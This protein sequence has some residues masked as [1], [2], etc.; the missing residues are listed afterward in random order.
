M[1]YT[2]SCECRKRKEINSADLILDFLC[3]LTL[4]QDTDAKLYFSLRNV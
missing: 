2:A 4:C 3:K 1:F